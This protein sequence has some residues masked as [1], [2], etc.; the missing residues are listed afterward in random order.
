[1]D[2]SGTHG[3]RYC[4]K[5]GRQ[6]MTEDLQVEIPSLREELEK[7]NEEYRQIYLR[8]LIYEKALSASLDGFLIVGRDGR[9][10]EINKAYCDYFG[11]ERNQTIGKHI[12][13]VISNSKMIAIMDENLTELDAMH[14]FPD[15][16][17]MSGE[18]LVAVSRM[19]VIVDGETIASVAIVKFSHYT[20]SLAK[21]LQKLEGEVAYYRKRLSR[22]TVCSFDDLPSKNPH[23]D[24]VKRMAARFA[25]SDLPILLLGETGVGKEV[26]AN[27]IHQASDRASHPIVCVNCASIPEE[28]LESELFGYVEGAFTGSRRSGKRGKFEIAD[29]GTLFLDEIG[30]MAP[31]MQSKLLRVLQSQE[32][33]KLG[34]EK[35]IQVSVRIIA[36][37][38]QDLSLAVQSKTFR[39]DL[40][41]RLNVLPITI[42]PLRDRIEDIVDLADAFLA[43]LV[44]N[45]GRNVTLSDRARS[46]LEDYSW[47]GN[48]RELRNAIGRAYMMTEGREILPHHLPLTLQD[49]GRGA[50]GGDTVTVYQA[51]AQTERDLII[52]CLE[53]HD[54]NFCRAAQALGIHR[55]TLYA[56]LRALGIPLEQFRRT[57]RA[58]A[59]QPRRIATRTRQ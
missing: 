49:K 4:Y 42:P 33:E 44:D 52:G 16:L 50:S 8:N 21:T 37:T 10:I 12:Y 5:I 9:I 3:A 55:A 15:G 14:T 6:S 22:Y 43:E 23:Y 24:E 7:L 32:V 41:Y 53:K 59:R 58:T 29:G 35:P 36:A 20:I 40:Y 46:V 17:S 2:M 19:P 45:Y 48:I 18:K 34:S 30:E 1:M 57:G 39:P 47:P 11:V 51:R 27:A 54:G 38:N 56:R 31:Q 28:L 25:D 13:S 26:F